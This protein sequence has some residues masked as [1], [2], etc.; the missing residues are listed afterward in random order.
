LFWRSLWDGFGL[1]TL[2]QVW[3]GIFFYVVAYFVYLFAFSKMV[4]EDENAGRQMAGCLTNLIAGPVVSGILTSIVVAFLLPIMLGGKEALAF[5][6][7]AGFFDQIAIAGIA[8]VGAAIGI[9]FVPVVGSMLTDAPGVH[10]FIIGVVAFRILAGGAVQQILEKAGRPMVSVYPSIWLTLAYIGVAVAFVYI[11][12]V[13]VAMLAV[14][15]GESA[16][17]EILK[18]LSDPS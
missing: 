15:L 4:G 3:A 11:V 12:I 17:S 5:S 9:G 7:I 16:G 1:L 2:W 18:A 8:G 6:D 10:T 13:L 14:K